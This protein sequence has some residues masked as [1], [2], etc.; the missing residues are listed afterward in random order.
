MDPH[1]WAKIESVYHSALEKE[2]G[3]RPAYLAAA[4]AQDSGLRREVESL[5]GC[6]DVALMG[7]VATARASTRSFLVARGPW[8]PGLHVGSYEILG[9][10]GAGGMGVVYRALD[11]KLRRE[12]AIK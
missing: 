4:C 11:T 3:E 12:V 6:A 10:L 8:S 9:Q 5:L 1:R 2:P 7:P